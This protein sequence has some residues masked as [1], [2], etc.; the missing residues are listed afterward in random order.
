MAGEFDSKQQPSIIKHSNQL[1]VLKFFFILLW[2]Y[3]AKSIDI[4]YSFFNFSYG[5]REVSF[6]D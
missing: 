2:L 6:R 3:E 5:D 1:T 4:I